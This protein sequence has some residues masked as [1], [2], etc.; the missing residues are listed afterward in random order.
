MVDIRES[1]KGCTE[2]PL[3]KLSKAMESADR[4]DEI[5][6]LAS[7]EVMPIDVFKFIAEKRGFNFK[8]AREEGA[9]YEVVLVKR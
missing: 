1:G 7:R 3:V 4:G 6:V 5:L 2:S 8:I 9:A